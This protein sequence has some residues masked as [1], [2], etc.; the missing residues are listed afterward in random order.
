[1]PG[2]STTYRSLRGDVRTVWIGNVRPE[3]DGGRFPVK[4]EVGDLFEVTADILREGHEGLAAVLKHR[5]V[6]DPGWREIRMEPLGN[7][8]WVAR[9]P[10]EEN[11]RYLYT[12][13]AYPDPYRT[14][15]E[16]L[17]KRL[18]AGMEVASEL[19]EGAELLRRT[20][21]RAVGADRKR[22]EARLADF[23]QAATQAAR[24]RI[25]LDDEAAELMEAYPDRSG[26]TAYDQELEVVVDRPLARF[27]AW[28]E[29]FPRSQ[30]RIPGRHGTF[31]DCM[32]RLPDIAAMGFDVIYLPPI[33]PI[34]T[35]FRKGKNNSLT[36]GPDDPGSPWAIGN[37]T[38]GHKAVEPALGT[39]DDFRAFIQ[40]A[41]QA[42]IEIAL[43]YALQ[44]SPDHPYAREHPEWFHRRPDGTIKYA[45]NPPKKYQDIYPL[46]FY[47]RD[48]E[49][50]WEEMKSILLF[51]IDQGVRIFRVDNPHTKPIPFWAW[52]IGEIQAVH[53]EVIFLSEAFT[54]PKVMQALAKA[55]FTQ[56]YT[57][58]TWRNFKS[59]LTDYFTELTQA[60]MAEYFRGNL[61]TNT[62]DILPPILQEGARPAFK[63]RLLLAATLS[64]VYGIYSGYELCENSAIPGTEEYLDSEKYEIKVRDWDAPSN[65]KD[66][67]GRIN[68]IRRE[69]RA[70]SEYR[71]LRF[72]ESDDDHMLFYGK[73]SFDG[74]NTLLVAVNL[75]PFEPHQAQVRLPLSEWGID[76]EE[77][78]Q[79]SDLISDQRY[80]WKGPVQSMRLDPRE[81]PAAI[82]RVSRFPHKDYRTPCY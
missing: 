78:F 37:E 16:D 44:C 56:S 49:A 51:W 7:D 43:D 46:N 81:E 23:E 30:G 21:P 28:Y 36:V 15:T 41:D 54:R 19:L 70:L 80:L 3:L 72:Y 50:L 13:V 64:S 17:K 12:I 61:F 82:L 24:A 34:G 75:D 73:R 47:C 2:A 71:N 63:M 1:M 59:E 25:L 53:P 66:Y 45:E 52:V 58:F 38:G 6:K 77:R 26:A 27:A 62:P 57:Y 31:K 8:R 29:M 9:F 67:I 65:I 40:A 32:D 5:T 14:W 60:D 76:P 33:H 20:L 22:L 4:R 42:G 69:N 68:R 18:A 35:S 11:T 48:R 74:N 10:L 79:V 55:G 39:L